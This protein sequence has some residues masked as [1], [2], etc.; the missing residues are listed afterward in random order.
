MVLRSW[1]AIFTRVN[2]YSPH[3]EGNQLVRRGMVPAQLHSPQNEDSGDLSTLNRNQT[4]SE[5]IT[6]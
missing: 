4:D 6:Y 3:F 2:A 5:V 1:K